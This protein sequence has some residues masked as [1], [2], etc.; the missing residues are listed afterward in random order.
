[1]AQARRE[2]RF[3]EIELLPPVQS[4]RAAALEDSDVCDAVF[5]TLPAQAKDKPATRPSPGVQSEPNLPDLGLL[6]R[7]A[8]PHAASGSRQAGITPGFAA[9]TILAALAVFWLC[10][11]H[12]LLY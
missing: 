10:G 5:E 8:G 9:F 12:A 4:A 3:S 2:P 11:G 6:K 1:M 7:N